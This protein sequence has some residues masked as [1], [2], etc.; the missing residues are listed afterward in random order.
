[1]PATDRLSHDTSSYLSYGKI[2][3]TDFESHT[4]ESA[5][6]EFCGNADRVVFGWGGPTKML[7]KAELRFTGLTN[8][9]R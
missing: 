1:M 6:E 9:L 2:N 5:Y 7:A 4:V 8:L 3:H